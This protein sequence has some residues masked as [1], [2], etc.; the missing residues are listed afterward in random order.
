MAV[1][2]EAIVNSP[3]VSSEQPITPELEQ[4]LREYYDQYS[5]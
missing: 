5:R 2:R 3:V 1:T 4:S